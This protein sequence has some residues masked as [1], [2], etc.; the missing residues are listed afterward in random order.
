M[1]LNNFKKRPELVK[2]GAISGQILFGYYSIAGLFNKRL[3]YHEMFLMPQALLLYIY[4]FLNFSH[5]YLCE[6]AQLQECSMSAGYTGHLN[7]L[8][9]RLFFMRLTHH[10]FQINQK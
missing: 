9:Y 5:D 7:N 3:K 8:D 10:F 6:A 1:L 4:F 2:I